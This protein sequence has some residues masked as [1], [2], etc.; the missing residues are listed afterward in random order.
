VI[1]G[2]N[3]D[4]EKRELE[5]LDNFKR[6]MEEIKMKRIEKFNRLDRIKHEDIIKMNRLE[7][8]LKQIRTER[9]KLT[10]D[11]K[12]ERYYEIM[13]TIRREEDI[14]EVIDCML[15]EKNPRRIT[16][17]LLDLFKK[18]RNKLIDLTLGIM[19][20]KSVE[21]AIINR[22]HRK[23]RMKEEFMNAIGI[24]KK[25]EKIFDYSDGDPKEL[26]ERAFLYGIYKQNRYNE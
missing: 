6:D 9:N 1:S 2:E 21:K 26:R 8:K 17:K 19:L 18:N 14:E 20:Y 23:K 11:Q 16:L 24:E 15:E 13:K 10:L 7:Q 12:I 3:M 5:R 22:E 4:H 25:P